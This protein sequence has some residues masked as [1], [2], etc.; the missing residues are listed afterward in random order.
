MEAYCCIAIASCSQ[1]IDARSEGRFEGTAPEP[2][3]SFPSGHMIGAKNVPYMS[4][5][6]S[7][8]KLLKSEEELRQG[9]WVA[10]FHRHQNLEPLIKDQQHRAPV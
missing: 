9:E 8:T 5:I 10:A 1:V 3:P 4:L 6:D 7:H 2:R